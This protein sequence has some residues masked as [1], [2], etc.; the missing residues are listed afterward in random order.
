MLTKK[1]LEIVRD[2][3]AKYKKGTAS[4]SWHSGVKCN[5]ITYPGCN[6]TLDKEKG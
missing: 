5:P 4:S 2:T 3:A 1:E 6:P